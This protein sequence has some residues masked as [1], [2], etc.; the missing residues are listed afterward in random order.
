[1]QSKEVVDIRAEVDMRRTQV[2]VSLG[3]ELCADSE[4]HWGPVGHLNGL[5]PT[6][7]EIY[8]TGAEHPMKIDLLDQV[9]SIVR[10]KKRPDER[11]REIAILMR[12]W[13]Q[14]R[15]G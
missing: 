15:R 12:D 5:G 10:R 11:V 3:R 4:K 9:V 13:Q 8:E 1:M 6:L 7:I 14:M 2:D